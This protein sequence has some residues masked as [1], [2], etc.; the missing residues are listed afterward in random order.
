MAGMV[1]R[2]GTAVLIAFA[3]LASASPL[4]ACEAVAKEKKPLKTSGVVCGSAFRGASYDSLPD[5]ELLLM[6][7]AG[8]AVAKTRTDA[9][10]RFQFPAVPKGLYGVASPGWRAAYQL[11]V[12]RSAPSRCT[13]AVAVYLTL[14]AG[15]ERSW[16][17]KSWPRSS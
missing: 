3:L 12:T 11:Q 15:C 1:V 8:V 2:R 4:N 7:S 16:L 10:G 17:S 5:M 9:N 6:D 13:E 14:G